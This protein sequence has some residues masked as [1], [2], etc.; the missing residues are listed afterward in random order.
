[1]ARYI[2]KRKRSTTGYGKRPFKKRRFN[3]RKPRSQYANSVNGK[4]IS[5]IFKFPKKLAPKKYRSMLWNST[6]GHEKYNVNNT[7]ATTSST[8]ANL[9]EYTLST[10]QMFVGFNTLANWTNSNGVSPTA[11][12]GRVVMRGGYSKLQISC[13]DDEVID[14]RVYVVWRNATSSSL[15]TPAGKSVDIF[16]SQG[17]S[18]DE[19]WRVKKQWSGLLD[20]SQ[21]VSFYWRPLIKSYDLTNFSNGVDC[22]Y[23]VLAVGN[24][25]DGAAISVTNIQSFNVSAATDVIA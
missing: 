5:G 1:M 20:R 12:I 7:I 16:H 24:T 4:V 8:P 22:L 17:D 3:K 25:I 9:T 23:W 21:T 2:Q 14:Y 18:T 15:T 10:I 13:K 19:G 11:Q 6:F